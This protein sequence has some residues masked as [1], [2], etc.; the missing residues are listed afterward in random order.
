MWRCFGPDNCPF[1]I[2]NAKSAK[3]TVDGNWVVQNGHLMTIVQYRRNP[4]PDNDLQPAQSVLQWR[5]DPGEQSYPYGDD[6][7]I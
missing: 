6:L 2:V 3:M 7:C 5:R 1:G 4:L